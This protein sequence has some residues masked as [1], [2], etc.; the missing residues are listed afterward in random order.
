MTALADH[1]FV[2]VVGSSGSGKSSVV[3]GRL[4]APSCFK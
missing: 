2:V 4:S 1:T 3:P